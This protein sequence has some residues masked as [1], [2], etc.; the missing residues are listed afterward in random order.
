[1][2]MNSSINKRHSV[3]IDNDFLFVIIFYKIL[4]LPIIFGIFISFNFFKLKGKNKIEY[5]SLEL[6]LV[7]ETFIFNNLEH[8]ENKLLLFKISS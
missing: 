5:K 4:F 3:N 1:M 2:T 6:K 7:E 8:K